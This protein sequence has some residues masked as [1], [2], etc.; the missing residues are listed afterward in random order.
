MNYLYSELKDFKEENG[1]LKTEVE[2]LKENF[3]K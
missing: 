3:E 1:K 2:D